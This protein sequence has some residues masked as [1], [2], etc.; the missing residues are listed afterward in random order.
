MYITALKRFRA[1]LPWKKVVPMSLHQKSLGLAVIGNCY[2]KLLMPFYL[3]FL[4]KCK[5]RCVWADPAGII[6]ELVRYTQ[7]VKLQT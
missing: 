1:M 4:M 3:A 2:S 6:L 5:N 7:V